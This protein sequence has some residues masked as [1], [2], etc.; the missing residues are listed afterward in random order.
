M[1]VVFQR[2]SSDRHRIGQFDNKCLQE[3]IVNLCTGGFRLR[4]FAFFCARCANSERSGLGG[5]A[6]E[7]SN[8]DA[9]LEFLMVSSCCV[10]IV[11]Q[12]Q[13]RHWL[14][15]SCVGSIIGSICWDAEVGH[16]QAMFFFRMSV[17]IV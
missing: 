9:V 8:F 12:L 1:A 16:A 11:D 7:A 15:G 17:A 10:R 6:V 13:A 14:L 4:A 5:T 2:P 3:A